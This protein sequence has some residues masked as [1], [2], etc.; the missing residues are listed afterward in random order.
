MRE[1]FFGGEVGAKATKL[2]LRVRAGISFAREQAGTHFE[3]L[4]I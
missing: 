3:A 2:P 1:T 4:G